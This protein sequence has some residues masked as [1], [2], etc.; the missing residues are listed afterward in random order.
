MAAINARFSSMTEAEVRQ[1]VEDNPASVNA[2]DQ[3]GCAPLHAAMYHF[4][5]LALTMW[6][7]DE[8]GADVNAPSFNRNV[9]PLVAVS[10]AMVGALLAR[11]AD[12]TLGSI[13]GVLPLMLHAIQGKFE[14]VQR[15]LQ[16]PRVLATIDP[17]VVERVHRVEE[18]GGDINCKGMTAVHFVCGI[19]MLNTQIV[20]LLLQAGAN[21]LL[22]NTFGETPLDLLCRRH[23]TNHATISLLEAA[24]VKPQRTFLLAKARHQIDSSH[25]LGSVR[26]TTQGRTRGEAMRVLLTRKPGDL[27]ERV[28][29]RRALPRVKLQPA[30]EPQ[31][32]VLNYALRS[33]GSGEEGGGMEHEG[34][35]AELFVEL[36]DMVMP[37]WDP[38]R[39]GAR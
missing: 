23:P 8:K 19:S 7:I 13:E 10:V 22:V 20:K 25:V 29:K 9:T 36:L 4:E 32:A 14:C 2:T 11:G 37:R 5:S 34:L 38:L 33:T 24:V 3:H 30:M 15:F 26:V 16:D 31:R 39:S 35:P 17:Q 28:K 18:E 1:W 21:P 6:L 12:P 27:K